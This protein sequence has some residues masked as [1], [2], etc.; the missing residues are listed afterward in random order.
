MKTA[1]YDRIKFFFEFFKINTDH[2]YKINGI[3]LDNTGL[4]SSIVWR[5]RECFHRTLEWYLTAEP[6]LIGKLVT[7]LPRD[8][9]FRCLE[10][11][12][13]VLKEMGSDKDLVWKEVAIPELENDAIRVFVSTLLEDLPDDNPTEFMQIYEILGESPIKFLSILANSLSQ[14]DLST[15]SSRIWNR[16]A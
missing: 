3:F 13:A 11:L 14:V 7:R 2:V 9:R 4:C 16:W 15:R 6:H 8:T 1:L 12:S 10:K 5:S